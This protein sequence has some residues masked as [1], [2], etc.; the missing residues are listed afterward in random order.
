MTNGEGVGDRGG[1]GQGGTAPGS[2]NAGGAAHVGELCQLVAGRRAA[3]ASRGRRVHPI[4]WRGGGGGG[5]G[6]EPTLPS[7]RPVLER[8]R[9]QQLSIRRSP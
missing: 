2:V 9:D 5:G 3:P 1:V 8:E 4:L 6:V 7:E